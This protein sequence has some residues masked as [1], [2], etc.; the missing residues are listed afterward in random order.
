M[1]RNSNLVVD[2]KTGSQTIFVEGEKV[3]QLKQLIQIM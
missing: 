1:L 2:F 3:L